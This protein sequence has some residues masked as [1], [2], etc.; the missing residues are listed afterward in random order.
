[1]P[2]F[3][4]KQD[5]YAAINARFACTHTSREL[6]LRI[7]ADGRRAFYRQCTRCESAGK[8]IAKAEAKKELKGSD[9][10]PF[11][12]EAEPKWH[13]NK[14]ATYVA[15]YHA[16]RPALEAEYRVYLSSPAWYEKR[17]AAIRGAGGIC[18]CCDYFPA[19]QAHHLTYERIGNELPSD[20]MAVCSY[21]HALI[22]GKPE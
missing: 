20:L 16:I 17:D 5:A 7:I 10:P 8:A 1:L 19:A 2:A 9:A 13:A 15:T 4:I 22:H 21:C 12:D 14:H 18:E 6:R 11:D 3:T